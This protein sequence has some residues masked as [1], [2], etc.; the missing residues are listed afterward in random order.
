[1]HVKQKVRLPKKCPR[2][3]RQCPVHLAAAISS[4][5]AADQTIWRLW[6]SGWRYVIT[7]S[8]SRPDA[9]AEDGRPR[10][11]LVVDDNQDQAESLS[12]LLQLLGHQV[13]VA[14]DGPAALERAE[15]FIPDV[16]LIDIGL[17]GMNGYDVARR[18][19]E[20]PA[21]HSTRLVAQTGWG[22]GEDR[23]RSE[24]A[25]FDHHLVKPLDI[26]ELQRIFASVEPRPS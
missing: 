19:R 5:G 14:H 16:A 13:V 23:R 6:P 24:E 7:G 9:P 3:W 25:G 4:Y 11:I 12:L 1:M 10:R 17:L 15:T 18:L 20:R 21:L 8:S 26:E 22:Q 2:A